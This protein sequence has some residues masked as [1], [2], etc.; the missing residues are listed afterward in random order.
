[1]STSQKRFYKTVSVSTVSPFAVSL[2]ERRLKTPAGNP[3]EVPTRALAEAMADEW[4]LQG[5]RLDLPSMVLTR[6]VNTVIDRIV[7]RRQEVLDELSR[8]AGSDLI[9]Y[10]AEAPREL[11]ARQ[12]DG[13][14]PWVDWAAR[15][16][17]VH[18][19]IANGIVHVEQDPSVTK[20]MHAAMDRLDSFRLS[21]LHPAVTITGSAVLGLAFALRLITPEEV[22]VT[23]C[24]D[25][26]YQAERW[27]RDAEAEAVRKNRLSELEQ[28][29]RLL[30]LLEG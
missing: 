7:P 20:A 5:E 25:E 8:Y 29:R 15:E 11:I 22:L 2:D 27:G 1:M 10:R 16:L 18:L 28:A 9:C 13:W 19:R 26:D 14:N 3:Q 24:I 30:D 4:R 21:A 12:E 17:G 23:S 6:A